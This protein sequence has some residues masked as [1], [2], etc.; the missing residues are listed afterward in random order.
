MSKS[1]KTMAAA[2]V[3]AATETA[4]ERMGLEAFVRRAHK[5]HSEAVL[6][7]SKYLSCVMTAAEWEEA[8]SA[9]LN[10]KTNY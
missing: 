8:L 3:A 4:V 10:H 6:L 2:P 7:R 5:T 9:M 1:K